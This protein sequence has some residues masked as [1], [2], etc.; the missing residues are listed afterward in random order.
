MN[1]TTK[2]SKISTSERIDDLVAQNAF[3]KFLDTAVEIK[4]D[5]VKAKYYP[6]KFDNKD[7]LNYLILNLEK[8]FNINNDCVGV[9]WFAYL[10]NWRRDKDLI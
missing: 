6:S 4:S 7:I 9:D 8:L 3:N 2:N 10:S 5:L 1:I